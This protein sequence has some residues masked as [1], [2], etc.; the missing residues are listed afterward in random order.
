MPHPNAELI[1]RLYA[2]LARRDAAAMGSCYADDAR[3]D[4][5]VFR[6]LDADGVRA[7]WHM[8]CERATD[9]SIEA[10]GIEA[11]ATHGKARWIATYT[12]SRTGRRV[13]N[14]I[15]AEYAFRDGRIVRHTDR[16]SLWRWAGMALGL[17]G[18]LLG[19]APPVREAIRREALR[20]LEKFRQR[21]SRR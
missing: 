6:Q 5:P 20:G 13:R 7:M 3:F 1:A 18:A 16:F 17:K 11:D 15:D 19:W 10:S 2:A 12:F 21:E 4:D 8:L 9:L 14:V